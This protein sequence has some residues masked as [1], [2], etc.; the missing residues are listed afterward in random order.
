MPLIAYVGGMLLLSRTERRRQ[1]QPAVGAEE[2]L[3]HLRHLRDAGLVIPRGR[4]TDALRLA[5][6]TGALAA[7]EARQP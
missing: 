5:E 7:P 6:G 1:N 4:M 3:A 2:R